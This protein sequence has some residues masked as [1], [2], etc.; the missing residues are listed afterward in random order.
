MQNCS[1]FANFPF[2]RKNFHNF[3][4][5]MTL[6]IA[7]LLKWRRGDG[8][9]IKIRFSFGK[10]NIKN[11]LL[12]NR[13]NRAAICCYVFFMC[14]VFLLKLLSIKQIWTLV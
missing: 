1:Y 12:Q 14:Y 7:L 11:A 6:A 8:G 4:R 9:K 13:I 10:Q 3:L 2:Y 5:D